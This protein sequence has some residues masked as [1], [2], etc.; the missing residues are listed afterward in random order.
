M[1]GQKP[2]DLT[3]D[4]EVLASAISGNVPRPRDIKVQIPKPLEAICLKAM[5]S[6][7]GD[8]YVSAVDLASDIERWLADEPVAAYSESWFER[9]TRFA[10]R[11]R[12]VVRAAVVSLLLITAIS[13]AA[14]ILVNQQRRRAEGL[15]DANLELAEQEKAARDEA[16][17]RRSESDA[18]REKEAQARREAETIVGFMVDAF[19]SPDPARDGRDIRAAEL[20][21]ARSKQSRTNCLTGRWSKPHSSTP[22]ETH[23]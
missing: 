12:T 9:T 1:T 21:E 16:E 5:A 2:I 4:D 20:L 15:A 6:A 13:T 17:R 18:A 19:Q 7:A 22:W 3:V 11:Y 14:S 23:T 10:R 8:R